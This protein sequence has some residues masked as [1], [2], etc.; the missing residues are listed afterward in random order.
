MN[1]RKVYPKIS[2]IIPVYNCEDT[3]EKCIE[4]ILRQTFEEFELILIDDGSKDKSGYICEKYKE[5]DCRV[6]VYHNQNRGVSFARNYGINISRGRYLM[7]CDSDDYVD[8]NWCEDLYKQI[9]IYP[10]SWICC[11][12]STID[13][14]TGQEKRMKNTL[15]QINYINKKD[16][17][18]TVDLGISGFCWNK[19]FDREIINREKIRFNENYSLGEDVEFCVDYLKVTKNIIFLNKYLYYYVK[20]SKETLTNRK[21]EN[22]FDLLR[23]FYILRRPFISDMYL[24]KFC[25][26]YYYEFYYALADKIKS[27]TEGFFRR[28]KYNQ[29]SI[30]TNE[31][32]DCL[33]NIE[34]CEYDKI[35]RKLFKYGNYYI[36]YIYKKIYELIKIKK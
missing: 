30:N 10:D 6:K 35:E 36:F 5:K 1:L 16:F 21:Y 28:L 11:N 31:F 14:D 19:I 18:I 34:N 15:N 20:Y 4:S 17:F 3:I 26:I 2:I 32:I 8:T 13:Y 24:E 22:Y 23:H 25:N 33:K 9:I 27:S 7:F 29:R 12:F